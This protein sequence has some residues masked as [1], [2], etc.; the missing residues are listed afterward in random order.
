[1]ITGITAE[2]RAKVKAL[3]LDKLNDFWEH[4]PDQ[5]RVRTSL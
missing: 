1:M 5:Q 2:H 3:I 4:S